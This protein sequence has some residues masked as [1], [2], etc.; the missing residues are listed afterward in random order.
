MIKRL[1]DI[2]FSLIVLL[3]FLPFGCLISCIIYF[4]S[5]GG[6]FYRQERVGLKGKRFFLFKFRTMRPNSDRLGQ[7]TVGMKDNRIT[8]IGYFLRKYKIDEFP[9]FI[10]VL[11]GEMSIVG[12]RPEVY[13]YVSLYSEKQRKILDVK[14]GITDY[15]SIYY[16]DENRL[17]GESSDPEKTYIE[18]IM[19]DKLHLNTKYLNNPTLFHDFRIIGLTIKKIITG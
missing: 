7:L 16:F 15:A 1:F 4:G 17:L 12:P 18:E 6:V 2:F 10:N 3:L 8:N 11:L 13:K 5:K 14:P 19:P 9:Q